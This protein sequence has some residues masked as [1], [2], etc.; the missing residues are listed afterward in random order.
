MSSYIKEI[1]L[2]NN[3]CQKAR[4]G[5]GRSAN[6]NNSYDELKNRYRYK[7]PNKH[8][9]RPTSAVTIIHDPLEFYNGGFVCGAIFGEDEWERM[10]SSRVITENTIFEQ[11]DRNGNLRTWRMV[12]LKC[13]D[14]RRTMKRVSAEKL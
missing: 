10:R 4:N 8:S 11:S 3:G 2:H 12:T 6:Y 5:N 14:G 7:K 1:H 13:F 9:G